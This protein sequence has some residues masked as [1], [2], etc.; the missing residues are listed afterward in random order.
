MTMFSYAQ[1]REEKDTR[2]SKLDKKRS[3]QVKAQY[4]EGEEIVNKRR[5]NRQSRRVARASLR[6]YYR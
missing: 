2:K 1:I 5:M 6:V 4:M 3:A